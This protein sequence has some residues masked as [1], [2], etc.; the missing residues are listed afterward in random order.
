[1]A[2]IKERFQ[3]ISNLEKLGFN[4]LE[5]N[6]IRRIAMT[7]SRC[8]E[9]ECNGD[10]ER[11]ETTGKMYRVYQATSGPNKR[12]PCADRERGAERR[13]AAIL[14][15]FPDLRS[16]RQCDPRGASLYIFNPSTLPAG[17]TIDSCYSSFGVAVY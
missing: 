11:D 4:Y 8:D 3:V 1:M 9:A 5:A 17:A 15:N 14:A 2:T 6:D 7:L 16:Y 10:T 12:Y 13:L